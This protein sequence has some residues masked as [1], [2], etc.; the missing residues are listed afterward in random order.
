MRRYFNE[1]A[2]HALNILRVATLELSARSALAEA[3]LQSQHSSMAALLA[4]AGGQAF[5]GDHEV[6]PCLV[7]NPWKDSAV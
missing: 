6:S 7:G 3:G 2:I 1:M 5:M 4:A